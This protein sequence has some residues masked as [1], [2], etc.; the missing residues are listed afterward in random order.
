MQLGRE[1]Q[2]PLS[3]TYHEII[4]KTLPMHD[5][6]SVFKRAQNALAQRAVQ[7]CSTLTVKRSRHMQ[8]VH[9]L[10][11]LI[12][13]P[14]VVKEAA[15]AVAWQQTGVTESLH[16]SCTFPTK[17]STQR[18]AAHSPRARV[19]KNNRKWVQDTR[20]EVSPKLA[21]VLLSQ[22]HSGGG[23]QQVCGDRSQFATEV[24]FPTCLSVKQ[25]KEHKLDTYW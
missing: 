8:C 6:E 5:D 21:G 14:R 18:L 3:D 4:N 1:L 19:K 10:H 23:C 16:L 15:A 22:V 7:T 13:N 17:L 25:I 24:M 12:F 20:G 11:K 9:A 2:S